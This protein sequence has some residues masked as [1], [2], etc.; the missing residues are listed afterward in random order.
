MTRPYSLV[1]RIFVGGVNLPS[2]P[3]VI[4]NM[5]NNNPSTWGLRVYV[6][7]TDLINEQSHYRGSYQNHKTRSSYQ[8]IGMRG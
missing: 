4:K 1:W 2:T 3:N 5:G 6:G 7:Q 8:K